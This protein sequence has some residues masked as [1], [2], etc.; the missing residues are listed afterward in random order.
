L[1]G[2]LDT[3]NGIA[4]IVGNEQRAILGDAPDYA[5]GNHVAFNLTIQAES[6][7]VVNREKVGIIRRDRESERQC[8]RRS[9]RVK[10]YKSRITLKEVRPEA[11]RR[12]LVPSVAAFARNNPCRDGSVNPPSLRI[13][14]RRSPLPEAEGRR[15]D[16]AISGDKF[17]QLSLETSMRSRTAVIRSIFLSLATTVSLWRK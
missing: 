11:W 2:R 7:P 9:A 13:Q 3:L 8:D 10:S 15:I 6:R 14:N 4:Y 5:L 16:P 1:I 12:V 17:V